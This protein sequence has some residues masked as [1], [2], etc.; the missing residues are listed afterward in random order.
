MHNP[1]AKSSVRI[2]DAPALHFSKNSLLFV[3]QK[4][5][6]VQSCRRVFKAADG[7]TLGTFVF[8]S[9]GGAMTIPAKLNCPLQKNTS[10]RAGLD[11]SGTLLA[12]HKHCITHPA[13]PLKK[14]K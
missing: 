3:S 12:T 5:K 13:Y 6:A 10:N 7:G 9:C 2:F 4:G 1:A 11:C 8:W 14:S